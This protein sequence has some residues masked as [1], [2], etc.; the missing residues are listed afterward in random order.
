MTRQQEVTPVWPERLADIDSKVEAIELPEREIDVDQDEEWCE[1]VVSGERRRIRFHDYEDLFQVPGLYEELFYERL[2]CC[3]PSYI[4]NLL[5]S[6][7]RE[8]GESPQEFRVLDVG[9]GNGMVGDELSRLG[10]QSVVG[11]DIIPAAKEATGRDRPNLYD[12]FRVADLSDLAEVEEERLRRAD[13]NCLTTVAALGYGDIPPRAF[14]KALDL[15]STPG[16]L[17]FNLKEDFLREQETSGFSRLIRRLNRD[18]FILTLCYRRYQHRIS[19]AGEPL[20]YV[21]VIAKKLK[22]LDGELIDS[23]GSV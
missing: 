19:I 14:A 15:I 11:I 8:Y 2:G 7:V 12:D 20:Y 3:S 18:G 17:A 21:A 4:S 6:V 5:D 22:D 1:V 10:V 23:L 16:W 9:A 13:A